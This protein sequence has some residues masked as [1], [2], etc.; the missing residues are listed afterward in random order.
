MQRNVLVLMLV[1]GLTFAYPSAKA[2]AQEDCNHCEEAG[3]PVRHNIWMPIIGM[4]WSCEPNGCHVDYRLNGCIWYHDFQGLCSGWD[5]EQ[6][7]Q[8]LGDMSIED[9][10]RKVSLAEGEDLVA[11]VATKFRTLLEFDEL[12]G[13]VRVRSCNLRYAAPPVWLRKSQADVLR[14]A[15]RNG[16]LP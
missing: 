7:Q 12:L 1:A 14:S 9:L 5:S 10:S 13:A 8:A 4:G 15:S 6:A 2:E 16:V 3:S 11:L